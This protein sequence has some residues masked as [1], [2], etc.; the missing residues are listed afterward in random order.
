MKIVSDSSVMYSVEQGAKRGIEVTPLT[1][2][3]EDKT[4]V[5]YEDIS[6]EEFLQL[7]HEGGLPKSSSPI[8]GSVLEAYDTDEEVIHLT[9]A[10]GLSGSYEVACGLRE[11]A[12][13]PESIHVLNTQTLCV[14]HRALALAAVELSKKHQRAKEVLDQLAPIVESARSCLLPADFD[15]LRRGGRLTPLAAKFVGLLKAAPVLCQTEDGT[16]LERL[17]IA[18]NF[19]KGIDASIAYLK[20]NGAGEGYFLGVSHADNLPNATWALERIKEAFPTCRTGLFNL[21]PAFI[22]QGGPGCVAVQAVD[23]SAFPHLDLD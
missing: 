20:K 23:L 8:P 15:F 11:Q 10:N 12:P 9:L 6:S 5:E 13:H 21:S 16:R 2:T 7:I 3:I 22:T 17:T 19:Q 18:R 14:P 1:V 4:W